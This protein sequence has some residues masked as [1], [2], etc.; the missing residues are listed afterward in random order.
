M[1]FKDIFF[2]ITIGGD[3]VFTGQKREAICH[4]LI[5]F[6]SVLL[7]SSHKAEQ[8]IC[9]CT[10]EMLIEGIVDTVVGAETL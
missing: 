3:S 5:G 6:R 2:F 9:C 1:Q 4:Q 7:S 10:K 8:L